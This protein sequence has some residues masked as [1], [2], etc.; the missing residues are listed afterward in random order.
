MKEKVV[1]VTGGAKGIGKEIALTYAKQQFSVIICDI[2]H[3]ESEVVKNEIIQTGGKAM[4]IETDVSNPADIIYMFEEVNKKFGRVDI[5]INNAGLSMWDS[6]YDLTVEKWDTMINTNLRSVFLCSREAAKLMRKNGGGSIVNIA[7][8]RAFM[9]EPN[10]EA[11]A[12]SKGG[13]IAITHAM[14]ASFSEDSITVNSI[15]PGWIETND[16]S[17]LRKNDHQQHFSKRVGKA[18]DI[19]KACLY[20]T[21]EGNNFI[22]GTNIVIDGGM[23]KKMIYEE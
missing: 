1:I 7:S 6:P 20:L 21:Q 12:A 13:I 10:S 11:Y 19:A 15:S 5:L 2:D 22:T 17:S 18:S 23:T 8:T 9:S 14:A 16:Y 3:K 4:T